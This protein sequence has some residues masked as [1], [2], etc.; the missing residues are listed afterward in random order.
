VAWLATLTCWGVGVLF[1][2]AGML[3]AVFG[4][5]ADQHHNLLHLATGLVAVVAGVS[6]DRS[7][8]RRFCVA[9]GAGYLAF[10]SLGYLLVT[11]RPTTCGT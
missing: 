1:V 4:E 6:R 5:P 2:A 9:F 10:G 11:H 8:A 7:A 3:T